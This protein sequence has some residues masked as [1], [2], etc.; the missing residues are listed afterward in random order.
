MIRGRVEAGPRGVAEESDLIWK[1]EKL[2]G[3]DPEEVNQ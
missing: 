3:R 2:L 1:A